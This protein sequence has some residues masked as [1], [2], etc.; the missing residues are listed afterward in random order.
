MRGWTQLRHFTAWS[1]WTCLA[2][3]LVTI[4]RFSLT[5][6][7]ARCQGNPWFYHSQG[8]DMDNSSKNKKQNKTV[9]N[10]SLASWPPQQPDRTLHRW[11]Q[12]IRCRHT[13]TDSTHPNDEEGLGLSRDTRHI[14]LVFGALP[15]FILYPYKHRSL[16]SSWR[17]WSS[18]VSYSDNP[19]SERALRYLTCLPK[20]EKLDGSRTGLK[21]WE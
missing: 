10:T 18:L 3:D 9:T 16:L 11:Q 21:V 6:H 1:R 8:Q 19:L 20:L 5:W 4:T 15:A 7:P 17:C 13:E 2:A 12:S 14:L